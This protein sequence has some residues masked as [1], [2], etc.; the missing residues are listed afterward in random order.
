[1]NLER[2]DQL[3]GACLSPEGDVIVDVVF[4]KVRLSSEKAS[5]HKNEFVELLTPLSSLIKQGP[6]YIH[7]GGELD[8]QK[9]ALLVMAVGNAAKLWNIITPQTWGLTEDL[10]IRNA[11]GLGLVMI[12]PTDIT[13]KKAA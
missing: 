9:R 12:E 6:S 13:F 5:H 8:D 10:E 4:F 2:I 1:M 11:A 3:I 7:L